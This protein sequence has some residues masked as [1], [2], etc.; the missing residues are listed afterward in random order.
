MF[1][2]FYFRGRIIP[3]TQ[4]TLTPSF[5]GGRTSTEPR[6]HSRDELHP[7]KLP[8]APP[9]PVACCAPLPP[10]R[11]A[12]SPSPHATPLADR[13][14]A[15]WTTEEESICE[16]WGKEFLHKHNMYTQR[17]DYVNFI[18]PP[19][20]PP[21][22]SARHRRQRRTRRRQAIVLQSINAG[23]KTVY[24]RVTHNLELWLGRYL[25]GKPHSQ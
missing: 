23:G 6:A 5:E 21:P 4:L 7:R 13:Q 14:A 20:C 25:C 16:R 10:R 8:R 17:P 15:L 19:P 18:L 22:L 2:M 11:T 24:L 12:T 1:V 9:P 3:S